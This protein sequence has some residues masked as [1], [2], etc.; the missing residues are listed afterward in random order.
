M[1]GPSELPFTG[2]VLTLPLLIVGLTMTAVGAILRRIGA[3]DAQ[4]GA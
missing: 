4:G 2:S 3:K 1:S